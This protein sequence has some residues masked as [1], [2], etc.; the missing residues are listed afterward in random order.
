M[1]DLQLIDALRN[2]LW[3][4]RY[5]IV[6]DDI[7]NVNAWET[8]KYAF[9]DCNCGSRII[10]TTRLSNL[11]ESI[12]NTSHVYELQALAENEAWTLFCM[13]A[14]RGEHKAVS[15]NN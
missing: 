11:A 9:P 6:L 12:E 15:N 4:R 14:F 10:F 3:R 8:I 2:Y 1:T 13:K 5:V 7:W